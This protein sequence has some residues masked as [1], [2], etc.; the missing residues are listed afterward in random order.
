MS[1][2]LTPWWAG[3]NFWRKAAVWVTSVMVL[4]LIFLTFHSLKSISSG[5]ERVPDYT[6]I[7]KRIYYSFDEEKNWKVPV[8]GDDAPLFNTAY[9]PQEA[10]ALVRKGKLVIQGRN[11]MNCHTLLGNGA[12]YAQD[13]TKAWLDPA[14]GAEVVRE[15][16]MLAFLMDPVA[17]A[18][19][20][21]TRR[22]MPNLNL[23]EEEAR[24]TIAYLKWMSSIDTNGFPY[25]F[26]AISQQ[27]EE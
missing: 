22:K 8:I 17:N 4:I 14:W 26:N 11:C 13:L 15:Q 23:S 2:E 16:L 24:A 21:G 18:R 20:Y 6:V 10:E 25:G 27:G 9:S 19:G 7:N 1:D 5:S 3:E 12:Y